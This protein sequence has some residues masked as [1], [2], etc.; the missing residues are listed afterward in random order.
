MIRPATIKDADGIAYVH[1]RSW[2]ETYRGLIPDSVLDTLSLERRATQWRRS[3]D[4]PAD[5][6]HYALVMEVDQK[7]VGFAN[8]GKEREG[9]SGYQGELFALYL[10]KEFHGRGLG[11]ALVQE[12][13]DGLLK[14]GFSSML[15]WV[16]A[17]NPARRFYQRLGGVYVREKY[18]EI[19][20]SVLLEYA[21]GWGNIRPLAK[22]EGLGASAG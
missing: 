18:I 12:A 14:S 16:L 6:Y 4:D 8:Y 22:G 2:Q 17:E 1:V 15:V 11:R 9:D 5:V 13:A 3:L 19:G 10:L 7:I 20:S 21:Y